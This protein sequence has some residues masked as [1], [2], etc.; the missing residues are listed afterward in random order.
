VPG[1]ALV[2]RIE[3]LATL[4]TALGVDERS[5]RDAEAEMTF[6]QRRTDQA[7]ARLIALRRRERAV[8]A[9]HHRQ[10]ERT[11]AEAAA[12]AESSSEEE[13]ADASGGVGR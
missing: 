1:H 12:R 2:S 8:E 7:E 9:A 4:S 5:L 13:R 11:F 3:R 6:A 10:L